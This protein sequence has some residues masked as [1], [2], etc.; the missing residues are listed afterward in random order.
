MEMML[1]IAEKNYAVDLTA[2]H[3]ISIAVR[4]SG[5]QL[6]VFGSPPATSVPLAAG[7]FLG[8][9]SQGGSCNCDIT[10]FCAHTNGT[11]TECVGHIT[12]EPIFVTEMLHESF[13]PATLITVTPERVD[14]TSKH[15]ETTPHADDFLITRRVLHAALANAKAAFLQAL[16][17]RTNPNDSGK[18]TRAYG[19]AMPPYFTADAIQF[20]LQQN[21]Q[22]L[23]VDIPSI[24]RLADEGK[25]TNHHLFWEVPRGSSSASRRTVTELAYIDNA[26]ADGRYLLNLCLAPML[27]DATPSRPLLYRVTLC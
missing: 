14:A 24:D 25:L 17:I 10:H 8:D 4:F 6:S 1:R 2:P 19:E 27:A 3:D 23:I 12:R 13:F 9:V 18:Q 7:N 5:E 11:H 22:H 20:L 21:V 16:V 15:Y 26:I